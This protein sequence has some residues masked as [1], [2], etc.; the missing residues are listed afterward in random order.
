MIM[1]LITPAAAALALVAAC[2]TQRTSVSPAAQS[3][4]PT[5]YADYHTHLF[6]ARTARNP[7]EPPLA[8]T[9][10]PGAIDSLLTQRAALTGGRDAFRDRLALVPLYDES[11]LV[12]HRSFNGWVAGPREASLQASLH[13]TLTFNG[14]PFRLVPVSVSIGDSTGTVAGYFAQ[15]TEASPRYVG[16]FMLSL[17]R[18]ASGPWRII[19]EMNSFPGPQPRSPSLADELLAQ[20]DS[21]GIRKSVVLA[22]SYWWG[23]SILA[24]SA[25]EYEEVKLEN[26]WVAAQV[27][28]FP[29]RLVGFCSFNPLRQYAM[30]E[31]ERCARN[32]HLRGIK[33]HVADANVDLDNPH[34]VE[35]LRA[36][37]AEANRLRLPVAAHIANQDLG[38]G[39]RHVDIYLE[40]IF[41][42]APDI[43]I[44]IA[45][46]AGHGPSHGGEAL[47]AFADAAE[48]GDPRM[49]NLYFDVGSNVMR[50]FPPAYL[51]QVASEIRRLGVERVLFATDWPAGG[52]AF[53]PKEAWEVFRMLPLTDAEF[54]TIAGN[55]LPH[56]R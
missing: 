2:A 6:S 5:P 41:S 17:V 7:L 54:A 23:S 16:Q 11:A 26:D 3:P 27:A 8:P 22:S 30:A 38:F 31:I 29:E 37:F 9:A 20:M 47:T 10:V 48:R 13:A 15:G 36:V 51:E 53:T 4:V 35:R 50:H 44:Q 18:R 42:A 43:T 24:E 56:V 34:H 49:R 46:L 32:P 25:D 45:H 14:R 52:P 21:A 1:R 39:R 19:T 12:I 55:V 40:R 33:L 28:R